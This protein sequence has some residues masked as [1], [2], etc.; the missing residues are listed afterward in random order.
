MVRTV[1]NSGFAAFLL[2]TIDVCL[3]YLPPAPLPPFAVSLVQ[4]KNGD[5]AAQ[6]RVGMALLEGVEMVERNPT[7]AARWFSMASAGNG[8]EAARAKWLL[9]EMTYRGFA[10]PKDIAKGLVLLKEA[11]ESAAYP[12]AAVVGERY[13]QAARYGEALPWLQSQTQKRIGYAHH[14]IAQMFLRGDGVP[15]REDEAVRHFCLA[16]LNA[17]TWDSGV[18]ESLFLLAGM[19]AE[20]RGVTRNQSYASLLVKE[21]G[22]RGVDF[23]RHDLGMHFRASCKNRNC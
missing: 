7:E 20:G 3:A 16:P 23:Q 15:K 14:R 5:V 10:I 2:L 19:Y 1:I 8:P 18:E 17:H 11:A 9:G 21:A 13:F 22:A 6:L 4:A 12:A